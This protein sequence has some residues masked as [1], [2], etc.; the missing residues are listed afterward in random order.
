MLFSIPQSS[1]VFNDAVTLNVFRGDTSSQP[2]QNNKIYQL[3]EERFGVKFNFEFLPEDGNLDESVG[4]ILAT[5]DYPDLFD[6]SYDADIVIQ[7]GALVNLLD[8]INPEDTPNLWEHIQSRRTRMTCRAT[9]R[10][11]RWRTAIPLSALRIPTAETADE[12]YCILR[13]KELKHL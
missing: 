10:L 5:E 13:T 12:K 7:A 4:L 9:Q 8:Y 1:A 3:I 11:T 2:A 6:A